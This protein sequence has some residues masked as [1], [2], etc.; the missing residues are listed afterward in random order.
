MSTNDI[1]TEQ[2]LSFVQEI[3]EFVNHPCTRI[4]SGKLRPSDMPRGVRDAAELIN[5]VNGPD[6][7]MAYCAGNAH[8]MKRIRSFM[9][10]RLGQQIKGESEKYGSSMHHAVQLLQGDT[11]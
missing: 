1:T 3:Y 8:M 5:T 2:L 7:A 9:I 11:K 4:E 6:E 10:T